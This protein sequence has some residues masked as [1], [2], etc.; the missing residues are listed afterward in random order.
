MP[1]VGGAHPLPVRAPAPLLHS[2]VPSVDLTL[3]VCD[4]S[5]HHFEVPARPPTAANGQQAAMKLSASIPAVGPMQVSPRIE[6]TDPLFANL[7]TRDDPGPRQPRLARPRS[8]F[9]AI[10]RAQP[11]TR[12]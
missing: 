8:C 12:T 9:L 3:P 1:R 4:G 7:E 5:S 2:G 10:A 6:A 11:P